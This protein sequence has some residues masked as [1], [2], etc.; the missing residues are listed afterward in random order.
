MSRRLWLAFGL[1]LALFSAAYFTTRDHRGHIG[2]VAE[3]DGFYYY[4]Y[5]RSLQLDGDIDL[6]NE[7]LE[8]ANPFG[9]GQTTTGRAR[10]VF[11]IGPAIA[12]SPFFVATNLVADAQRA[13]GIAR[14]HDGFSRFHQIGTL[15]G[16]LV[17][18]W[19]ALLFCFLIARRWLPPATAFALATLAALAGPLPYY[20]LT[21]A[22]YAHASA[23]MATSLLVLLWLRYRRDARQSGQPITARRWATLGTVFG[24]ALLMRP[25]TAPFVALLLIDSWQAI[26]P[27]LRR[28]QL[29]EVWQAFARGPLVAV[30]AATLAFSPQLVVWALL[31]GT[32]F[33]VPQGS[34]FFWFGQNAWAE[35]L[36]SPRNGLFVS[37]PLYLLA[38]AGL[39]VALY[40]RAED[41]A[42]LLITFALF[43]L[44]NGA[45]HDWWGWGFS[46]RRFSACLPLFVV[47]L[48]A[49]LGRIRRRAPRRERS[50]LLIAAVLAAL[51]LVWL[52]QYRTRSLNYYQVRSSFGLYMAV[53]YALV[54][55]IYQ[56]IGN[57]LALPHALPAT[58]G[59]KHLSLRD[60][61]RLSGSY[62][63]GESNPNTTPAVDPNIHAL[64]DLTNPR[65]A[66]NLSASAFGP[67]RR[68]TRPPYIPLVEDQAALKLPIN[69]PGPLQLWLRLMARR[70][71]THVSLKF[72]GVPLGR[73]PLVVD[74]WQTI[75]ANVEAA[76]IKRGINILTLDH[77]YRPLRP[78][79]RII[80]STG[81]RS[82]VDI[83]AVGGG[84]GGG[85]FAELFIDHRQVGN[86]QRG[87]NV[88]LV[89]P[90]TGSL[91]ALRGFD[92]QTWHGAY[93]EFGRLLD[94]FPAGTIVV[95]AT[96][97]KVDQPGSSEQALFRRFGGRGAFLG[98]GYAAI[99]V[100]G[101]RP[102][103]AL[104]DN[105]P[106]AHAWIGNKPQRWDEIARYSA[107]RL[108]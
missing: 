32:I 82:P 57:P 25:A 86:N 10:N 72:N 61:D 64:I 33:A 29:G 83:A 74:R 36:F 51:N 8:W 27:A 56:R 50:A 49:G 52:N 60:Y 6:R 39:L 59:N 66:P 70:Q 104:E 19:L 28:K 88:A 69:R 24:I 99:G 13:L 75:A 31:N 92:V 97:G 17:Y 67:A 16:S 3:L 7:Y 43:V 90:K 93:R 102:G 44:F 38:I 47:G 76:T 108:H 9:F 15:Y 11:G 45:V 40:R 87:L 54:D 12:W 103:Q 26:R 42:P 85:R 73:Y 95:V 4:A 77:Q 46:A 89:D 106:R 84:P 21:G 35:S 107:L 80:G 1:L 96:R 63:L 98:P 14:S 65:H 79:A 22:S 34:G 48:A 78:A 53:W 5:L 18:G 94:A 101:A 71:D 41:I 2:G 81:V 105:A 20:C 91:R 58:F 68:T 100:L 55:G 30:L 37:A 23:T 62:L